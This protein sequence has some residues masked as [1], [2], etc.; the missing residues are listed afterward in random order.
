MQTQVKAQ[1]SPVSEED[2]DAHAPKDRYN[3]EDAFIY[4]DGKRHKVGDLLRLV[5][6]NL[7]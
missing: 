5:A 1:P 7:K 2:K 3:L 4:I 6:E